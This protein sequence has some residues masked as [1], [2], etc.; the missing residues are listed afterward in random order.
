MERLDYLIYELSKEYGS[1]TGCTVEHFSNEPLRPVML[2][3]LSSG[4]QLPTR[5]MSE[6]A[7]TYLQQQ[8][9][10]FT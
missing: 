10:L 6:E 8:G 9:S 5:N 7:T 2:V 1:S 4:G 3:Q